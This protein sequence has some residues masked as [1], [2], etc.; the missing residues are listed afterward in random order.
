ML[1]VQVRRKQG[2]F[3]IDAAFSIKRS[4]ITALFGPSGA[5]KTSIVNMVAGLSRPDIGRIVMNGRCLFDSAN[6]I[7]VPPEKRRV[8]YVFQDARLF[9]HLSVRSNLTYGMR[10]L[11]KSEHYVHFNQVVQLLGIASIL[12]RRPAKL[13]GGE[14]QRVA[15]G[16]ALLCSPA[17]LLM[18]EPL[19]SL[20]RDRKSEVLPFIGRLSRDFSTPILYVSH[21]MDEIECLADHL[22]LVDNG[23]V[24]TSGS[25]E[26][27]KNSKTPL[28]FLEKK[29]K[30]TG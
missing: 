2:D 16:R 6:G 20:D 25:F 15:I 17:L 22:V 27:L 13:S 26:Q 10:L 28:P 24:V 23:T 18:D 7:N 29:R 11:P 14:K 1:E 4:G 19:A 9:P 5:G 3:I 21:M 30:I 8:G 12:D